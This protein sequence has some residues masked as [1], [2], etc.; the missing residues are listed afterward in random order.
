MNFEICE[1]QIGK[2]AIQF[3]I[4]YQFYGFTELHSAALVPTIISIGGIL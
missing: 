3:F 4:I 2:C 1:K